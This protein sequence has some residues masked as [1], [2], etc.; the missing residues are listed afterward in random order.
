MPTLPASD[1]TTFIKLQASSLAYQNG[2]VPNNI[3]TSDQPFAT[4]SALYAQLLASQAALT[5]SPLRNTLSPIAYG[6]V[7]P[8]PG[9]GRV[10]NPK[11]LSTVST[12]G[13]DNFPYAR[14]SRNLGRPPPP[15][16]PH[17]E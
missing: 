11:N 13:T 9:Y 7:V 14:N 12:S 2:R 1:Y 6:R 15:G 5:V 16:R 3:Q 4:G 8:Y 17:V 10:N